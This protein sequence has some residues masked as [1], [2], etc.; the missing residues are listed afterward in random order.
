MPH[1]QH[2]LL[3][4]PRP[5]LLALTL[6]LTGA[7]T[8]SAQELGW[9]TGELILKLEGEMAEAVIQEI[10]A[11]VD[12][13]QLSWSAELSDLAERHGLV[14]T[15]TA[16]RDPLGWARRARARQPATTSSGNART[17]ALHHILVLKFD[18]DTDAEELLDACRRAQGV[19]WC[20]LNKSGWQPACTA[21]DTFLAQQWALQLSNVAPAWTRTDGGGVVVAVIDTGLALS[22]QGLLPNLSPSP[23][24]TWNGID[25][26]GN[27]L[28]D[29]VLG[30]DFLDDDAI[31]EDEEPGDE[32]SH[33][34]RASGIIAAACDGDG[35]VGAAPGARLLPI[36]AITQNDL[37]R[38]TDE[39]LFRALVH[40]AETERIDVINNSW[41]GTSKYE[42]EP[43]QEEALRYAHAR[44]KIIVNAAGNNGFP[45]PGPS[46]NGN[47]D[48]CHFF[49]SAWDYGMSISASTALD[50]RAGYSDCGVKIDV[51][52][53]AGEAQSFFDP[54]FEP[55]RRVLTTSTEGDNGS[56]EDPPG[57]GSF[58]G[59]MNGTSAAAPHVSALAAMLRDLQPSWSFEEIRQVI[60]Q[61]ADDLGPPG[62]DIH[63]GYGRLNFGVAT[64]VTTPPPTS[65]I[66][67]PRNCS[68][69][70]GRVPLEGE[71]ASSTLPFREWVLFGGTVNRDSDCQDQSSARPESWIMLASGYDQ[72][73]IE[74]APLA[75]PALL[76]SFDSGL[77][78]DGQAVLRLV[79]TA[80]DPSGESRQSEDRALVVVDN[81]R[82]DLKECQILRQDMIP[83]EG[84][85]TGLCSEGVRWD[86]EWS[87]VRDPTDA[88]YQPALSGDECVNPAGLLGVW[89]A[90]AV[91]EGRITLRL[92]ASF[93]GGRVSSS[94]EVGVIL[95]RR[96]MPGWPVPVP[97][98]DSDETLKSPTLIDLDPGAANGTE[99]IIGLNAFNAAGSRLPGWPELPTGELGRSN[100][101]VVDLDGDGD[102]EV[103]G[104]GYLHAEESTGEDRWT[105]YVLARHHDGRLAWQVAFGDFANIGRRPIVSSV[106]AARRSA[107]GGPLLALTVSRLA[108]TRLLVLNRAGAL[109]HDLPVNGR[110]WNSVAVVLDDLLATSSYQFSPE[111]EGHVVTYSATSGDVIDE[112]SF[113][114]SKSE[115]WMEFDLAAANVDGDGKLEYLVSEHWMSTLGLFDE[116]TPLPSA[117]SSYRK[118]GIWGRLDDGDAVPEMIV[119]DSNV[120]QVLNL[121]GSVRCRMTRRDE[122]VGGPV[123]A[124]GNDAVG[125][126]ILADVTG[127]GVADIVAAS[128]W[129]GG[130]ISDCLVTVL[131]GYD[132]SSSA[133]CDAVADGFPLFLEGHGLVWSTPA[134]GDLDGDGMADLAVAF[135][136]Q[137]YVWSL[138]VPWDPNAAQWPTFGHDA[139][140]THSLD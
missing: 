79:S 5:L 128:R 121:D 11:G 30:W 25:D 41:G 80:T 39:R 101:A 81:V 98:L 107:P 90:T 109:V 83:I 36:R 2:L 133:G 135:N 31:P 42:D 8:A 95:D 124:H 34:T 54:P 52:G 19:A 23:T 76:G 51:A 96:H 49:P 46:S 65:N 68:A 17:A 86:L 58:Y 112:T 119:A 89:D 21:M 6:A 110:G 105:P 15:R 40:A 126:P 20:Q 111:R 72:G 4:L 35:T 38:N 71:A 24:E 3:R 140:N 75:S 131:H 94:D 18:D 56:V 57:G 66:V 78:P 22:H 43:L 9:T 26:D 102:L 87:D 123:L 106:S 47:E 60:R 67:E 69:I 62:H 84:L 77:L 137:I 92:T 29:D 85:V 136:G 45:P 132:G 16:L 138:G 53:P 55:D 93:G 73:R 115:I 113:A 74:G 114:S 118:T 28:V 88:D 13:K 70:T 50:E 1:P 91:P 48:T 120:V 82:I 108:E 127:D 117:E 44:N 103:V 104:T 97:S 37:S 129:G 134:V 64:M 10:A 14:S 12:P 116:S 139:R 122:G 61:S 130:N 7:H 63:F 125:G 33:G 27:G 99:L 59:D 100:S 32:N